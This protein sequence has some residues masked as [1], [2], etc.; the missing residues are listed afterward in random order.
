MFRNYFKTA[1][2]NLWKHR[3]FSLLNIL[4]LTVGLTACFLIFLYV[5]FELSYDDFHSK[6]D[7]IYRI[8][9][10]IKTPT[11]TINASGK[12]YST[13]T[14]RHAA[15]SGEYSGQRRTCPSSLGFDPHNIAAPLSRLL[16]VGLLLWVISS[17][18][19]PDHGIFSCST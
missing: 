3:A 8:T 4:G 6:A 12:S 14:T 1:F 2:R 5:S 9:C 7:R 16:V 13:H 15:G 10:D 19:H 18:G 17:L 11:E